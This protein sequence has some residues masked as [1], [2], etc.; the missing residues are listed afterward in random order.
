[1]K[2][3]SLFLAF[4]AAILAFSMVTGAA[5]A[6]SLSDLKLEDVAQLVDFAFDEE[7]TVYDVTVFED[8]YGIRFTPTIEGEGTITVT[9][10]GSGIEE[11]TVSIS[12]GEQFELHLSQNRECA[13]DGVRS[14]EDDCDYSVV[15]EAA[16]A[17]YTVNVHRP[18]T[19]ALV[20]QFERLTWE[21]EDG[22]EMTYWLYVPENYSEDKE[23]PLV[24]CP[25]GGGQFAVDAEDI[26]VRTAQATAFAK[27][28]VEAIVMAPHGN[29]TT[30]DYE[31]DFTRKWT[32]DDMTIMSPFATATMDIVA[33]LQEEYSIDANKISVA[34]G[35]Q[36]GRCA[37]ALIQNYPDVFAAGIICAP[38]FDCLTN[39]EEGTEAVANEE[40]LASAAAFAQVVKEKEID[41]VL[42]HAESD[43]TVNIEATNV[44][45]EALDAAEA[46]YELVVYPEGT[47]L[48]PSDHFSWVPYFDHVENLNWL[49]T[50]SK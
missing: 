46:S 40:T 26:L 30:L 13:K 24:V 5:E 12:A 39:V 1:M 34:G 36:G 6:G 32:Q 18:G 50:Q 22:K 11:E 37:A 15:I 17:A 4:S 19:D 49:V 28:G 3:K 7:T 9:T 14:M 20:E 21:M 29:Y 45:Q 38:A 48:Y 47:Y 33:Y 31:G 43:P 41:I 35:S 16:N 44:M 42:L 25:H 2:R 10:N 8:V 23:Y 27:Y